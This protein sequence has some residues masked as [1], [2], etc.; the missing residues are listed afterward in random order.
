MRAS[1]K[2]IAKS[3]E[4][5]LGC[6]NACSRADMKT[7]IKALTDWGGHGSWEDLG[8]ATAKIGQLERCINKRWTAMAIRFIL[9]V[10]V[11]MIV[12]GVLAW[13]LPRSDDDQPQ[14]AISAASALGS[15]LTVFV[16]LWLLRF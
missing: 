5:C 1:K 6:S 11:A 2:A 10:V 13:Q 7:Y 4:D 8:V 3:L 9:A 14:W 12:F 15:A 16:I